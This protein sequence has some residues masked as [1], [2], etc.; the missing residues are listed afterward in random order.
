MKNKPLVSVIVPIYNVEQYLRTCINS[1]V[2][3][4]YENI[5]I[6]LVDDESPDNSGLIC[7]EYKQK[8]KRICVIHQKNMGLS[9]ARNSGIE[10]ARGEYIVF[11][12]SDD[13]IE[14][15]YIECMMKYAKNDRIVA[16]GFV[17][18]YGDQV[19][20]HYGEF[21]EYQGSDIL[22]FY[23]EDE[24]YDCTYGGTLQMG[25]YAWNKLYPRKVFQSIRYPVGR[26]Y[27]DMA[28]V[29]EIFFN[30]KKLTVISDVLYHYR[31]RRD[32]ITQTKSKSNQFEYLKSRLCQEEYILSGHTE[33]L[34]IKMLVLFAAWCVIKESYCGSYKLNSEE[35][36]YLKNII[37]NRMVALS[38]TS[39]RKRIIIYIM[40]YLEPI[41][42]ILFRV[43]RVICS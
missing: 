22:K 9:G 10:I 23:L 42:K 11:I 33:N 26:K 24:A 21:K 16:C 40:L 31:I 37:K 38:I 41:Y 3:Q 12:D 6:I 13:W 4:T 36:K 1:I 29:A 35:N 27:E 43:K 7:E 14:L 20:K 28:I 8:D 34:Y 25:S 18:E 39:M 15:N 5:E 17:E 2:K 32:S 30:V 19:H